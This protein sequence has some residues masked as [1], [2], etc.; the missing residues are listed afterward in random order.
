MSRKIEQLAE[1][2]VTGVISDEYELVDVEYVKENK[3]MY[4]RILIDKAGGMGID[5]CEELSRIIGDKLDEDDFIED[6]YYLEISSPGLDRTLKK[7]RDFIREA[8][9]LV[10]VK[11]FKAIEKYGK[12]FVSKLNGL[13]GNMVLL[14]VDGD[15]L[16]IDKKSIAKINLYIEF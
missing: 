2:L 12:E 4:L 5:D 16:E 8:G 1:K 14:D 10:E 13:N 3:E 15:L 9:K 6:S 7:D 11:L